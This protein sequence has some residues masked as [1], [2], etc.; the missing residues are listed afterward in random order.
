MEQAVCPR[1]VSVSASPSLERQPTSRWVPIFSPGY[2]NHTH[3]SQSNHPALRMRGGGSS[4]RSLQVQLQS[5]S[6]VGMWGGSCN[7][8]LLAGGSQVLNQLVLQNESLLVELEAPLEGE[9]PGWEFVGRVPYILTTV[10]RAS[11]LL[12]T[13]LHLG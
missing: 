9:G 2:P 8:S 5:D 11:P 3:A 13:A 7:S 10:P 1:E 6:G 12:S 4:I